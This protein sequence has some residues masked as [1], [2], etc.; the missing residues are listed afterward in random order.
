MRSMKLVLLACAAGV[1]P[2][3]AQALVIP[4]LGHNGGELVSIS[5]AGLNGG[6]VASLTGGTVYTTDRSFAAFP[7]GEVFQDRFLAAGPEAG[8]PA[9]LSF[10][11]PLEYLSFLWGSPDTYNVLTLTTNLGT[12]AYSAQSL[13]FPVTNGDQGFS[14]YVQ[15]AASAGES[16]TGVSFTNSPATDAFEVA[17]FRV[18]AVP[19]PATWGMMLLG[20]GMVGAASRYRRRSTRATFA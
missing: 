6:T 14:Q 16:I 18:T 8:Q 13:G 1:F 4:S 15:F 19:E 9:T 3:T 2:A 17:N 5:T 11:A 12:Y 10:T 20:F 7:A